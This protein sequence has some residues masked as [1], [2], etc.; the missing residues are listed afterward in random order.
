MTKLVD[1]YTHLTP[2]TL[3]N[4]SDFY[5]AS[6]CFKDPF[7]TVQDREGITTVFRH[8]FKTLE[9]PAFIIREQLLDGDQAFITWDFRFRKGGKD[10]LLHGGSHLRFNASGKVIRHRDYWDSAEE[11][12]HKLPLI[13]PPLRL[14]RRMLSVRDEGESQ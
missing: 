1:W 6:A 4:I 8:M 14:L 9:T 12:L 2:E 10:Y 13:G 11:L 7:N 5:A 3:A